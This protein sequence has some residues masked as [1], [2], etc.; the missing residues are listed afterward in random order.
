MVSVASVYSVLD[1]DVLT[2]LPLTGGTPVTRKVSKVVCLGS[3]GES[4][5]AVGVRGLYITGTYREHFAVEV[6]DNQATLQQ[7]FYLDSEPDAVAV[8]KVLGNST[9][10]YYYVA[11]ATLRFLTV[12]HS[13]GELVANH[14]LLSVIWFKGMKFRDDG[15]SLVAALSWDTIVFNIKTGANITFSHDLWSGVSVDSVAF[16]PD[17][18]MMAF[19]RES[20]ERRGTPPHVY[21]QDL[22]TG[23]DQAACQLPRGEGDVSL[24]TDVQGRSVVLTIDEPGGVSFATDGQGRSVVLAYSLVNSSTPLKVTVFN[25][26]DQSTTSSTAPIGAIIGGVLGGVALLVAAG[27]GFFVW[28]KRQAA[29]QAVPEDTYVDMPSVELTVN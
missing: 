28:T 8:S 2:F 11:A 14:S 21:L 26:P 18:S 7:R 5:V 10:S 25:V 20:S 12:Y 4:L 15:N 24:V 9:S 3:N 29:P 1:Y 19:Y 23:D 16:N 27:V 17:G 22:S 6:Y 13:N